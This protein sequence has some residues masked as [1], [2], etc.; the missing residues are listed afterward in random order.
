MGHDMIYFLAVL[1]IL[2]QG[3]MYAYMTTLDRCW[4][5][6]D[7]PGCETSDMEDY[8]YFRELWMIV[9]GNFGLF[10]LE[11]NLQ[12]TVFI[13]WSFMIPL[14]MTSLLIS[15]VSDTYTRV[16][17]KRNIANFTEMAE[18]IYD[19]ELI[20]TNPFTKHN[21]EKIFLSV[22][23]VTETYDIENDINAGIG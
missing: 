1:L 3:F 5:H 4:L 6:P 13:M 9:F 17:E 23:Q 21:K 12:V 7:S 8:F 19:L 2:N 22:A 16:Y 20:V 14:L 11:E 15:F 18:L 10:V